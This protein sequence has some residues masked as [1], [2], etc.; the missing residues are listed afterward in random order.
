MVRVVAV[1]CCSTSVFGGVPFLPAWQRSTGFG[2]RCAL[3]G[4]TCGVS[5]LLGR[6]GGHVT[7]RKAD[8][9]SEVTALLFG[10]VLPQAKRQLEF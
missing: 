1:R 4:V 7:V 6:V 3:G 5:L 8:A 9:D 2:P 10:Y